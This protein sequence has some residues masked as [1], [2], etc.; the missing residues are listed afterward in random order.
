MKPRMIPITVLILVAGSLLSTHAQQTRDTLT[1]DQAISI[2]LERNRPTKNAQLEIGKADEQLAAMRTRRLPAFKLTSV[3]SQP[4]NTFDTTFDKGI[5]GTFAGIGPVP[6]ENTIV[7]SS[8]NPTTLILGQVSQPLSRLFRTSLQLKQLAVNKEISETQLQQ[9]RQETVNQVKR[10]YYA[11]LQTQGAYVAAEEVVK[12]YKEMNRITGEYVLQQVA[13]KVDLMDVETKLAKAEYDVLTLNNQLSSQREQL[14]H[15][16]GRDVTAD[17]NVSDGLD[18]AQTVMRETDLKQAHAKALQHRP[19]LREA[20]L[21]MQMAQLE[22]RVKKSEFIPDVSINLNYVSTFGYSNF[23]PRSVTGA[24]VQFE[25]EVFDWGRKKREVAEKD[26]A[27]KQAGNSVS[28]VESQ[29]LMEVSSRFRSMH[30]ACQLLRVAR[31]AQTAAR[32]NAQL[33]SYKFRSEAALLKDVL[34]AQSSFAN[35]NYDYQKALVSFWTAKADFEKAIG[36]DR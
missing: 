7:T 21:R 34:Q 6:A 13:L 27:I 12:L 23:L 9:K 19:E 8:T 10:A 24:S 35:A 30:E 14:N 16:L 32:A 4:L 15:L 17:F 36:E 20:R 11:M 33:V 18:A 2:A 3:V 1:L 31:L 25:W 26:L 28:E 5:F 29:V 22:K